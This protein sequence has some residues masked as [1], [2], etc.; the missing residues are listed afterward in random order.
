MPDDQQQLQAQLASAVLDLDR[1]AAE[2]LARQLLTEGA[3]PL[4]LIQEV[5]KPTADL[6][7]E[8]FR[9][10]E[11]FLPQLML[12]GQALEASMAVLLEAVP[13]AGQEAN[14]SVL[15]G[16][17]KGDVHNIGKN[18]VAM[19][20]RTGG[21]DVHDLGI[22]VD[23]DTFVREAVARKVDI[24]ALSSL[25]TTTMSYQRDVID[26]LE[27]RNVRQQFKVMVGGGPV[28]QEWADEIGADGFGQD[29]TAGLTVA[30]QL[31]QS[32]GA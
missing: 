18:V 16:T 13:A 15:I 4:A 26:I 5:I 14:R 8:K 25:L 19:M 31:V 24:I 29:A 22:D 28:T 10:E 20:L 23:A 30:R 27:Y 11:F 17:V 2:D 21:F 6:I 3:D 12:A 1:L 9:C 32:Q 7:G